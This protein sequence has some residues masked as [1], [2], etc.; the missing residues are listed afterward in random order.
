MSTL[1]TCNTSDQLE[2]VNYITL[3][4]LSS[5]F[6]STLLFSKLLL[7]LLI[8]SPCWKVFYITFHTDFQT[9]KAGLETFTEWF[10]DK[11]LSVVS[12]TCVLMGHSNLHTSLMVYVILQIKMDSLTAFWLVSH[13][14]HLLDGKSESYY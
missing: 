4:C 3:L 13:F 2:A 5:Y 1:L 8:F 6:I 11:F 14:F 12:I 10:I 7:K 9:Q